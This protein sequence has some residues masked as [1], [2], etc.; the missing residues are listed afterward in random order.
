MKWI[1]HVD[2]FTMCCKQIIEFLILLG[3]AGDSLKRHNKMKFSTYDRDNDKASKNCAKAHL[4]GWWYK[5]CHHSNL[6]GLYNKGD[7]ESSTGLNWLKWR[8]NRLSMKKTEMKVR[9][10]TF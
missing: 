9:P 4:G 6:N 10:A 7:V 3:N 2:L 1:E 8:E 5:K